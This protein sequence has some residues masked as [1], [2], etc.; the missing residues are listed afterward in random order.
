MKDEEI[1]HEEKSIRS[2]FTWMID[3][4]EIWPHIA[5]GH[6]PPSKYALQAAN[7]TDSEGSNTVGNARHGPP[8]PSASRC[9]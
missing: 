1:G 3:Y 9:S 4:N 8:N 5:L 2:R 6:I 7:S